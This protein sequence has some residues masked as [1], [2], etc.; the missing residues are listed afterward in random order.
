MFWLAGCISFAQ[1]RGYI[2]EL[3]LL[4]PLYKASLIPKIG[5]PPELKLKIPFTL[6]SKNPK[7]HGRRSPLPRGDTAATVLRRTPEPYPLLSSS[8]S[9]AGAAIEMST[10]HANIRSRSNQSNRQKQP[11][12]TANKPTKEAETKGRFLLPNEQQPIDDQ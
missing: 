12:I 10:N 11:I 5:S 3:L 2:A 6:K 9:T 7:N 8:P 1:R 4:I